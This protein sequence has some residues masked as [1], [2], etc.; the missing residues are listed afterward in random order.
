MCM[1]A[2]W[3]HFKNSILTDS[4]SV[5]HPLH[6]W[7]V[8]DQPHQ[9]H[10]PHVHRR[11]PHLLHE[12]AGCRLHRSGQVSVLCVCR[13]AR[14]GLWYVRWPWT[15][16][17]AFKKNV[18]LTSYL[19]FSHHCVP[20]RSQPLYSS[21][22]KIVQSIPLSIAALGSSVMIWFLFA[23]A[24]LWV[25]FLSFSLEESPSRQLFFSA[26]YSLHRIST[27]FMI[28]LMS[29]KTMTSDLQVALLN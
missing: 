29:C 20:T 14:L 8:W 18:L 10:L 24:G 27:D 5:F 6:Q 11:T 9:D 19:I 16:P 1:K 13:H 4:V 23:D 26:N 2:P 22:R 25:S 21:G 28:K 7:T 15:S 3:S 17:K 12:H